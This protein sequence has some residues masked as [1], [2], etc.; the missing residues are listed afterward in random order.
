MKRPGSHRN[1][2]EVRSHEEEEISPKDEE[3]VDANECGGENGQLLDQH[4]T[5][6]PHA[7]LPVYMTIHR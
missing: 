7:G 2:S 5:P 6:N 1:P 4:F 3:A